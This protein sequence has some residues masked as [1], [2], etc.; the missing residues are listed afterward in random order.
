MVLLLRIHGVCYFPFAIG[1]FELKGRTPYEVV[2]NYTPDISECVTFS[3]YQWCWYFDDDRRSKS[4]CRW[5]R[6]ATNIGQTLCWFVIIEN[7]EYLARSSVIGVDELSEQTPELQ[8]QINKFTLSLESNV[9]NNKVPIFDPSKPGEIYCKPF[10]DDILEEGN[11]LPYGDDLMDVK[12]SEIGE[13]YME[14]LDDLIESRV[15]L[16]DK[17]GIPLLV[18]VKKR[19]RDAYGQPI[20]RA[21]NNPILDSRIYELEYSDVR[22]GEYSVNII[23][24]NMVE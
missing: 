9:G 19:K 5:I 6:P 3:W 21:N 20:G 11:A 10:G 15:Q 23:L 4:L 24:E 12:V 13:S 1:R 16:P 17:S 2:T 18:T 22:V 8:S 7:G 14:E